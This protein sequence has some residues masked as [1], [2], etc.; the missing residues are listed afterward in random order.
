[1]ATWRRGFE[2][3]SVSG[4]QAISYGYLVGEVIRRI[5]GQ[6]VGR[7]F[8]GNV[9]RPLNADVRPDVGHARGFRQP[10]APGRF[11][12]KPGWRA[13]EIPAANGH[14]GRGARDRLLCLGRRFRTDPQP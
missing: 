1:M 4:Y 10:P 12:N 9:A 7:F 14:A 5:S 6:S 3:G 11:A 13:A 8:A 2:P